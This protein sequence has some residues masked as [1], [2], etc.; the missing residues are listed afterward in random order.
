[1]WAGNDIT[2]STW[3]SNYPSADESAMD[4]YVT[5]NDYVTMSDDGGMDGTD[6]Y[7]DMAGMGEREA[8]E[9][10]T[11]NSG[12]V[13]GNTYSEEDYSKKNPVKARTGVNPIT[14]EKITDVKRTALTKEQLEA[15]S[16]LK[17]DL[18]GR[19]YYM[20]QR[21]IADARQPKQN[22]FQKNPLLSTLLAGGAVIGAVTLFSKMSRR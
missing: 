16:G 2:K 14:G 20:Q 11:D 19:A 21:L 5:M 4:D 3:Y 1:M 10:I 15:Q 9:T 13:A 6:Q 8:R 7:T 12:A 22:W 17:K 18:A